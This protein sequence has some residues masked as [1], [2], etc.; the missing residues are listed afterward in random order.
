MKINNIKLSLSS[1]VRFD[2]VFKVDILK[3][4]VSSNLFGCCQ[5]TG[6]SLNDYKNE[7][8]KPY[9][10]LPTQDFTECY[11][12][13]QPTAD[14]VLSGGNSWVKNDNVYDVKDIDI[15]TNSAKLNI[16]GRDVWVFSKYLYEVSNN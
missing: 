12:N 6:C 7:N 3:S 9:H 14:Q 4:P 2:G 15:A 13:G 1:K 16:N 8:V 10:W 11:N 5:L